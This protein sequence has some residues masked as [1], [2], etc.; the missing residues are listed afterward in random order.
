[1][2]FTDSPDW[3]EVVTT[4]SAAGA[5]PDAPD[6]QR[7]VV[8]PGAVPIGG[9]AFPATVETATNTTT[10]QLASNQTMVTLVSA[11][12]GAGW[13]LVTWY[14][15]I[16][17]VAATLGDL[18]IVGASTNGPPG[19]GVMGARVEPQVVGVYVQVDVGG[20]FWY[21]SIYGTPPT[22]V[23]TTSVSGAPA[24]ATWYGIDDDGAPNG[25]TAASP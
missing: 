15:T 5:M 20:S 4:V 24:Q 8:G 18:V 23:V 14:A 9:G 3:Q 10:T 16:G 7:T 2:T 17:I 25:I 1:M 22:Y 21:P 13:V 19:Y 11:Y 6:W 12:G